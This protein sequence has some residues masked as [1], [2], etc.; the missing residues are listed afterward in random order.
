[1]AKKESFFVQGLP[2]LPQHNQRAEGPTFLIS[3]Q[4]KDPA[5]YTSRYYKYPQ[6]HTPPPRFRNKK[7]TK[8]VKRFA[9][10]G[11][12]PLCIYTA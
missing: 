6:Q 3:A 10:S 5:S 7:M 4:K 12:L 8:R 11:V 9:M 2:W 1:M